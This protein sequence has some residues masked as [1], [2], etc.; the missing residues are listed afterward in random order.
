MKEE[1]GYQK[2]RELLQKVYESSFK[3]ASAYL[4]KLSTGP[5]IKAK[6]GEALRKFSIALTGCKNILMEIGYL[7][8]LENPDTLRAIVQRLPFG[9]RQMARSGGQHCRNSKP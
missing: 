9:L 5:A 2:A 7:S 4:E 8:K 3:I 1:S 6:D